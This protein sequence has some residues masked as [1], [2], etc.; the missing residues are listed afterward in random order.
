MTQHE[1][2]PTTPSPLLDQLQGVLKRTLNKAICGTGTVA[3]AIPAKFYRIDQFPG[4]LGIVKMEELGKRHGITTPFFRVH[5]G[6]A[7]NTTMIGG[8]EYIHFSGY[9]YLDISGSPVVSEAAKAA[10]DRYG[11]SVSASRLASGEKPIHL[12]L[13]RGIAE[14]IGAEDCIVMVSGHAT[15]VTTIGH[16]MGSKDLILHDALIHNSAVQGCQLS[17]ARRLP[18]PHNDWE[19]LDTLLS[20]LRSDHERVLIV[21]EGVY[22]M[23]G[24]YP[25]LPEFIRIKQRYRAMLMVDEAHSIGVLGERG[26]GIGE[27]FG[28]NPADVDIWMGTLSKTLASCGGYIAGTRALI[29]YLKHTAPGFVFS[30]GMTPPNAAAALAALGVLRAEPE[31]VARLRERSRLLLNLAR[32]AGLDTGLAQGTAIV[33]VIIGSTGRS[34]VLSNRLFKRGINV[35]PVL[36]PAVE[37]H[38]TRLRFF[39]S[40]AH[41][42]EQIRYTVQ[43]VAEEMRRARDAV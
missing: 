3:A 41:T 43:A 4:Y 7:R 40:C 2:P 17:G 30:A 9:N 15:N 27:H 36:H 16:L 35:Q 29:K 38:A 6:V 12:E 28:I 14:L 13:E 8:K 39:V 42:E 31:R 19:A 11:T 5:D 23:D 25:D 33:P 18:F 37:E 21:L 10:I 20:R 34:V 32:A 26:F 22:S 1:T 24:D